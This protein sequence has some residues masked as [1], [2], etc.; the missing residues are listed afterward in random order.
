LA[1]NVVEFLAQRLRDLGVHFR[2]AQTAHQNADQRRRKDARAVLRVAGQVSVL[3]KRT[4][5]ASHSARNSRWALMAAICLAR[6][7]IT[8]VMAVAP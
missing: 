2:R 7:S 5:S 4:S 3:S 8:G 6:K 1:R